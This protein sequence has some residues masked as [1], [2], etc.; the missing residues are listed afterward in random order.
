M[1]SMVEKTRSVRGF[2]LVELMVAIALLSILLG[3][4]APSF[5]DWIARTKIQSAANSIS[6]ALATARSEAVKRGRNVSV[7]VS[8]DGSTCATGSNWATG[9]VIYA[10][11]G[12]PIKV[13]DAPT[14]SLTVTGD[15][16]K[17]TSGVTFMSTGMTTLS[18][19]GTI[20]VCKPGLASKVIEV[21]VSGRTRVASGSV[22]P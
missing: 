9:W 14:G 21:A 1:K 15:G 2:T 8:T 4:A 19:P 5:S 11:A 12:T 22:C 10:T 7:C 20:S 16:A 18:G 6:V 3:L 17:I 13:F